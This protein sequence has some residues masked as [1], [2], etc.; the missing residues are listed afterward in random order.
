MEK[1]AKPGAQQC[2]LDELLQYLCDIGVKNG[3]LA[4]VHTGIGGLEIMD[5]RSQAQANALAQAQRLMEDLCGLVGPDGT[6][7]MPTNATY[8]TE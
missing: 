5:E 8:Q 7:V 3:A 1:L 6:L 4:M 2:R